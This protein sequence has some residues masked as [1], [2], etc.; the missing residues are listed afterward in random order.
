MELSPWP[1]S[2]ARIWY[3]WVFRGHQWF[4]A[5]KPQ[6]LA[7]KQSQRCGKRSPDDDEPW[8]CGGYRWFPPHQWWS[9]PHNQWSAAHKSLFVALNQLAAQGNDLLELHNRL[10]QFG[11]RLSQMLDLLL[12]SGNHLPRFRSGLPARNNG[13]VKMY[14]YLSRTLDW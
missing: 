13:W 12:P 1:A 2:L 5:T 8:N 10:P 4:A 14:D 11:Y 3:G 6:C 9:A 7:D